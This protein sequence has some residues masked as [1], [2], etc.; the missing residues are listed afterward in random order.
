MAR[1]FGAEDH[2]VKKYNKWHFVIDDTALMTVSDT[3]IQVSGTLDVTGEATLIGVNLS[4][5]QTMTGTLNVT[6]GITAATIHGSG[7]NTLT[8]TLNV[9]DDVSAV[10][11]SASGDA[12]VTGDVSA[13][14]GY[15][16]AYQMYA[17]VVLQNEV[18][19]MT[20]SYIWLSGSTEVWYKEFPMVYSGSVVGLTL[21]SPDG[22]VDDSNA[23]ALTASVVIGSTKTSVEVL[24]S[25]G[26]WGNTTVAKDTAGNTFDP[27]NSVYVVL[28][29]SADYLNSVA[30]SCSW[31]ANIVVE[32]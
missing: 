9:S 30:T 31:I 5:S 24:M 32:S 25:T 20:G 8:G 13:A 26:S 6:D 28:T 19:E 1:D 11:L 21:R 10:N 7:S 12:I 14:G 2:I 16:H 27:G 17:N 15:R 18:V 22:E 29:A 23:G 3:G 4:G